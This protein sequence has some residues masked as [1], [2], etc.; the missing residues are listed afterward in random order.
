MNITVIGAGYVGLVTGACFAELGNHVTCVDVNQDK[1]ANL[2]KGILPI[3]EPGLELMVNSNMNEGR[4]QFVHDMSELATESHVIF[5][6]V[7]TPSDKDGAA[8]IK[9]V[10]E[11][12]RSIGAH[13]HHY[14]VIVDKSTVSVGMA[15]QVSRVIQEELQKR[16]LS[17]T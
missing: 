17:V 11:A 4:L 14:C 6:A 13:I 8:D 7:G 1:I 9:Y 15:D 5:I 12:A 16:Q 2:K 3:Y 10:L